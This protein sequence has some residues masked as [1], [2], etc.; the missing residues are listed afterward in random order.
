M[1]VG[2]SYK[3]K[4]NQQQKATMNRW[5]DMLRSQYNYLL[6]D[7]NDSYDQAKAPRLGNYCDLKSG[8]EACPLTCSV[9]K[10][11]SVGY[12]WKK[13]QKNPRRSAYEAQSSSLPILKKER[14][15]YK[16]IHSTVLQ[17]TLRQ[18]DV[19]FAKFFKGETGYPKPKRRSRFRSFKYAPGQVKLNGN[20]IYLPGI[21]WMGFYNSRP[22]PEGFIL[23]SVTVRRKARGWFASLQIEDKSVPPTPVKD[24]TEINPLKVKGCDLGINKLVSLSNGK[25]IANPAKQKSF[26]RKE[27]RLNLRQKAASRKKKESKNRGKSYEAVAS[28]HERITNSRSAYH[29]DVANQLVEETDAL[30]FEDLNIKAMKSR[31]KPRPNENGGYVRNGQSAKRGLN[32]SISNAAWGELVKKIEVVAAKSGIPVVKINPKH[33]S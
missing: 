11:Y 5:L 9:S 23:K 12:P 18:L 17:Q 22:I 14:P 10:N 31:C 15:W 1:Q 3:L 33:T 24:N 6:R 21:G 16:S 19:A 28:L 30:V 25:T 8:R 29:W 4:P 26:R 2:Y 13:S 32:R 20:K 7:R 27:R